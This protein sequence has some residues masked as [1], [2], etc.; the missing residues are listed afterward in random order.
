MRVSSPQNLVLHGSVISN[1]YNKVKMV[2]LHKGISFHEKKAAP[3]QQADFLRI[4]P[5]GLIPVLE[6]D[7]HFI[8]ESQT[9][10]EF[11]EEAYPQHKSVLGNDLY[12]RARVRQCNMFIDLY[13]DQPVRQV[14][15]LR[16]TNQND[17]VTQSMLDTAVSEVKRGIKALISISSFSP[18]MCSEDL[19]LADLA[20][21][22]TLLPF[23]EFMQ[24]NFSENPLVETPEIEKYLSFL[25][26]NEMISNTEHE[27]IK[28]NK[29]L[30]RAR[31]IEKSRNQTTA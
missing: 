4:S 27:R 24:K 1:Y 17:L 21:G 8:A 15:N 30:Q 7:G 28:M 26:Q 9:I 14:L 18:Y 23:S 12:T 10:I 25:M 22:A 31:S 3:S 16:R 6:A 11:L 5:M 29:I 13:I 20:A 19:T 2:L